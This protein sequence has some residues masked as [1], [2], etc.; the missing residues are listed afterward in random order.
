MTLFWHPTGP[1]LQYIDG[2]F[3]IGDLNPQVDHEWQMGRFEMLRLGFSCIAAALLSG[4]A[5]V[6]VAQGAGASLGSGMP[7]LR[8]GN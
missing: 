8:R 2:V 3:H 4:V 7:G 6:S 1:L 5:K